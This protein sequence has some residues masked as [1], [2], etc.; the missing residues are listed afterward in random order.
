[1]RFSLL[2]IG[3]TV[4][5]FASGGQMR[6]ALCGTAMQSNIQEV[7]YQITFAGTE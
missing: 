6:L 3:D 2:S 4:M 7:R 5:I 1:M